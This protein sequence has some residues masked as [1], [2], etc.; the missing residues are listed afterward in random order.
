M[1]WLAG[2]LA[3]LMWAGLGAY[4]YLNIGLATV[5]AQPTLALAGEAALALVPGIALICA[6]VMAR[7]SRRSTEANA[8]VLS[9]ARLLLEP[10]DKAREEIATIAE[11]VTRETQFVNKALGETRSK[12][13]ALRADIEASVT[14]ALKAAEIVRTDSEVLVAK[15][16]AERKSLFELS[17]ALKNQAGDL[18]KAIPRHAQML[19]EAARVAQQ[20]VAKADE[21]M[22]QRLRGVEDVARRLAER[23]D[24]LDTMGA[25]SR[26]RAQ[27]L[28]GA[29][30]RMDEQLVQSTRMVDAAV[31]AGELATAASKGTADALRDAMSDALDAALKTSETIAQRSSAAS[32]EARAAMQRLKDVGL[33]VEAATKSATLAARAHADEVD[34]RINQSA[35]NMARASIRA[36]EAAEDGLERAKERIERASLL[37]NSMQE[38]KRPASSI[39]GLDSAGRSGLPKPTASAEQPL[40]AR[41]SAA[42][43]TEPHR[44]TLGGGEP[45]PAPPR[46]TAAPQP[47]ADADHDAGLSWR[48]LLTGIEEVDAPPR[49]ETVK[50]MISRLDRAGV[51]LSRAVRASD[52]R[53][54]AMAAHQGERQRRRATRDT[55]PG[56]IQRV[57]RL[58]DADRE[59]AQ[60]ARHFVALEEPDALRVLA[61]A[62]RAREDAA[63]RLSAYLFLD[64]AL[65]AVL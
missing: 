5:L 21:L 13:D 6:G 31:K 56:E 61:T 22:D 27:N 1:P 2:G 46:P 59:L 49:E 40:A 35:D 36:G 23:I 20:E 34:R 39:D 9:S 60:A 19:G 11:A 15:M 55:N 54:I 42:E 32:E 57:A 48:D 7:E 10:A 16:A 25:E 43:A 62:D 50:E 45:K 28:A 51:R 24:Q 64:A 3:L 44:F 17:E 4:V 26:K 65:G 63:P 14:G 47:L 29:L 53:R 58:L 33:Q 12:L 52:L 37:V 30:A 8:L 38:Q 41:E 18:S